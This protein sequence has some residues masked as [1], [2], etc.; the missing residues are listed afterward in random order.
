MNKNIKRKQIAII[1]YAGPE[2]YPKGANIDPRAYDCAYML[3]RLCGEQGWSVVTGGKSGVM[4]SANR[5][6][7]DGGGISI[8][9]V[10]GSV[11]G[12]SNSYVDVEVIPGT[13]NCGEE[14][15]LVT[16]IDA[17]IVLGGGM[18]TLQ[19]V[20]IAY[21]QSKPIYALKGLGGWSERLERYESLDQRKTVVIK[22]FEKSEEIIRA[23]QADL[24]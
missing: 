24:G 12:T 23:L 11:R 19:E 5:G 15:A 14:M 4:E 3:G 10:T 22:Y 9:V 7:R 2:E 17:V 18:G 8:G 16:M 6:C 1:G 21:R 20:S 13:Y